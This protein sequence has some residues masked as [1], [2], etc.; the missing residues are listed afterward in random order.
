[1][2]W[3]LKYPAGCFIHIP[4]QATDRKTYNFPLLGCFLLLP[5]LKNRQSYFHSGFELA[6][7]VEVPD[8]NHCGIVYFLPNCWLILNFALFLRWTLRRTHI[9]TLFGKS[10]HSLFIYLLDF[11]ELPEA[12]SL[13]DLFLWCWWGPE[14]GKKHQGLPRECRQCDGNVWPGAI[15]WLAVTHALNGKERCRSSCMLTFTCQHMTTAQGEFLHHYPF[16][17]ISSP[18]CNIYSNCERSQ[19]YNLLKTALVDKSDV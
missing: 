18:K 8:V 15:F 17:Q 2:G 9:N 1:M 13:L 19:L 10:L 14:P 6:T 12:R 11:K 16:S 4:F 7:E 5:P 3:G